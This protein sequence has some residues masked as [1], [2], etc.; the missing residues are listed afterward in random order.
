MPKGQIFLAKESG[1]HKR[2][3]DVRPIPSAKLT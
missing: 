2:R 1:I 3:L